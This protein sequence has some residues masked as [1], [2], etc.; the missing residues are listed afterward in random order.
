[1]STSPATTPPRRA[2]SLSVRSK[3]LGI[4]ALFAVAGIA[5]GAVAVVNMRHLADNTAELARIQ[6]DVS[7]P[8]QTVHQNQLKARMIIAQI[9]PT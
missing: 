6:A 8:E 4:V 5:S 1:M 2:R 3:I 7:G 9:R